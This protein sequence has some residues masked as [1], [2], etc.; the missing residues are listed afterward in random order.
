LL[1]SIDDI[2]HQE[3]DSIKDIGIRMGLNPMATNRVLET[4]NEHPDKTI[5]TDK[6][7]AI[8]KEQYN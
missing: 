4:M 5:P 3:I 1:I 7:I 6:L 2:S 8:F